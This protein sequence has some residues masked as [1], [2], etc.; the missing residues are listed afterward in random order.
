MRWRLNRLLKKVGKSKF[1]VRGYINGK[2]SFNFALPSLKNGAEKSSQTIRREWRPFVELNEKQLRWDE[3][4]VE[5]RRITQEITE[6]GAREEQ[7]WHQRSRIKWLSKGGAYTAFFH[8]STLA[9]RRQNCILRIKGDD[10]CWHVGEPAVR[11]A[12]EEYFKNLFTSEAQ[13]ING[14]I[15]DCV[16]SVISQTTNDNLLQAITMEEI[17]EAAMQMGG[18]KAPGPDGYQG[19]FFHKYWDTIYDE[20]RG[21]TE[22]F[23]LKNQSLG[24]LNITNLVLIPKIPNPKGVSHF[25]PISLCNFSFKIV[26]KVMANRLKVFLPQIISPAQ[27]AF[28]YDPGKYLGLPTMWGRSKKEALQFVKEKLLRKLSR[29]KQSLL[30]Q[31]GREVLIKAVAQAVPNYPMGVFLFPKTLRTKMESEIANF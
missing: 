23:F 4:H 19:I 9:R 5:I 14:D 27:N 30:S 26:S 12:F 24:A 22:D 3:N 7:Y 10:G 29:W 2:Q 21:I 16:D 20:V 11:R 28:D 18:L 1:M 15:L 17:K 6:T 13:S 25:R 8:Q 31:A